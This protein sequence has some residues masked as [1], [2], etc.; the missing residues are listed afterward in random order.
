MVRVSP[1]L[2][3]LSIAMM[4]L[5]SG[6]GQALDS[7]DFT[8]AGGDKTLE[9]SLRDASALVSAEREKNTDPQD[10]FADARAEY[11]RLLAALYAAGHYSGVINVLIDGREA[12]G[13]APLDAP[14]AIGRIEV[15]VDPGPK[16]AFSRT[17]IAPL[18]PDT[19]LPDGFRAGQAALSGL[20][21]QSV[22]AGI[23]GWRA[24]GNAKAGV[25]SQNVVADHAANT[26]SAEVALDPGPRLRFGRLG[27][28][29]IERMREARVRKIAGLPEG[30]RFDPAELDRAVNRLRRTGV[31]SSVSLTEADLIRA[32]DFVDI[33]AT[34]VEAKRRR[35]TFGAEVASFDGVTLTGGWLHRNLLGGG[36][37]LEIIG[38]VSNI[39]VQEGGV[40][41]SLDVSL[42]RPA[43]P[44]PD[45]TAGVSFGIGHL[46]E[47]DYQ[48]DIA[49]FGVDFTHYFSEQLTAR[50]GLVYTYADGT[51]LTGDFLYRSLALPIGATWDRRDSKTDATEGFYIDAEA[52]PFLGFGTTDNGARLTMDLRGYRGFGERFVLAARVQAGAIVGASLLGAPRDDLF[53]SGGGGTVRGQPYQSLGETVVVGLDTLELGGTYFLGGSLEARAKVGRRLGVVGF[54]DVGQIGTGFGAADSDLHAGAGV[55]VRYETGFG[56]IRLDVA[57]PVSGDTGDGVQIYVGLGQSF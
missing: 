51:D 17:A 36:E 26:L 10:L 45:T 28:E 7:L 2:M 39:G 55:G 23:A 21:A 35:Y 12:A 40:D 44:G 56:P 6:A 50:V 13:I 24:Q 32:P 54:F 16:F 53:Y 42:L 57:T 14:G 37:R 33:M 25:A 20:V 49:R 18:A 46:D 47:D 22:Q 15:R 38:K 30:D 5:A 31:F 43:T 19:A 4:S 27:I 11:G 29:G 8:V 48:A 52:K 1:R 9:R 34:L 41:Y 3:V